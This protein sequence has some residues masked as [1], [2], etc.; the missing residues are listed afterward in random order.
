MK[1]LR[2]K[3]T[4][5]NVIS[6]LCLFLL[7]GGGAAFAASQLP[8]NSVGTKQLKKGSITPAK[9]NASAKAAL[10]GAPGAAG[11]Q[12]AA[13]APGATHVTVRMAQDLGARSVV[14]CHPGEV[15]A[16][17]GGIVAAGEQKAWIKV[18]NPVQKDGQTPTEWEAVGEN[19]NGES[20]DVAAYVICASP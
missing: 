17:G 16:G 3:L 13:G 5:A 10:K 7:L 18:S 1:N 19:V 14:S 11:A 12:G 9:L 8:K 4:Y 15:A 2:G 20:V 6:T